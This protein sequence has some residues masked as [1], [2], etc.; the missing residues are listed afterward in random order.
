MQLV[1]TRLSHFVHGSR[2]TTIALAEV[3]RTNLR[4]NLLRSLTVPYAVIKTPLGW[5][6]YW[7]ILVPVAA[8]SPFCCDVET[9]FLLSHTTNS[10]MTSVARNCTDTELWAFQDFVRAQSAKHA[11]GKYHPRV[12]A[13][14]EKRARQA[15]NLLAD[16][17]LDLKKLK[18]MWGKQL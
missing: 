18:D 2:P 12:I 10:Y 8:C 3:I 4:E 14:V 11:G 9:M 17:P 6:S 7:E 16:E 13:D 1:T 5:Q 15:A